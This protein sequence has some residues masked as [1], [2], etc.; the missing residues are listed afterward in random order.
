MHPYLSSFVRVICHAGLVASALTG[1]EGT[2]K[3][4]SSS[5]QGAD[6]GKDHTPTDDEDAGTRDT[7]KDAGNLT[8]NDAGGSE[9]TTTTDA[10]VPP[11]PDAA[12]PPPIV[13]SEGCGKAEAPAEGLQTLEVN[14][15]S[16]TFIVHVPDDYDAQTPYPLLFGFHGASRTAADFDNDKGTFRFGPALGNRTILVYP[17][18]LPK[19]GGGATTWSRD[20]DDDL[21]FF[22]AMLAKLSADTCVNPERVAATGHSSGGYFA[23]TLG[24]QRGDVLRAIAPVSGVVR[25]FKNC[26]GEVAVWMAHGTMDNQVDVSQ[27]QAAREHWAEANACSKEPAPSAVD[28]SPCV[29]HAGCK[30][31]YPLHWCAHDQP[32]YGSPPTYHGWPDFATA[33]IVAFLE[34]LP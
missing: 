23:N 14:G 16:R 3:E 24:C 26:K 19:D 5:L 29:A 18:A 10:T 31:G 2:L 13:G 15:K 34:S 22:D 25:D 9:G 28:P 27:G 32:T 20:T 11:V 33:G 12:L 30:A 1:C 4:G 17:N 7:G 6:A 21:A 8:V